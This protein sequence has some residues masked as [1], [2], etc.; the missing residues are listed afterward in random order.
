VA[1]SNPKS[2]IW[3]PWPT[4]GFGVAIF[5]VYTMVQSLVVVVFAVVSIVSDPTLSIL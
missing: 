1:D 2:D 3:G 5:V 4:V